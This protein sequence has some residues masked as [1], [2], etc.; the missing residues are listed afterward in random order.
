MRIK[1]KKGKQKE[2]LNKIKSNSGFT[3][4]EL[5]KFLEV[6]E[7]ALTEWYMERN[8]LPS[9]IYKKIDPKNEYKHFILGIKKDNWGKSK[10]GFNSDG[11]LKKIQIPKRC[12]ELAELIGI[13]LG[14]G[15]VF[16]YKKGKKIG[17]YSL[18]IAGD[19]KKDKNYHTNYII[20]LCQNLFDISVK[21]QEFK[22]NN[23]RFVS[24]Y[25]RELVNYLNMIGLKSG[26]KIKNSLTMP[27]WIFENKD[28]MKACIR[29]LIDTDGSVFRMSKKDPNLIRINFK[30]LN[31]R[32]LVDTR[33]IFIKLGYHPSKIIRN[34]VFY[35]SRKADITKYIKE[36][37]FSNEKHLRRFKE[38]NSSVV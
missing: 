20:P 8:L 12:K 23:E 19:L 21:T 33:K 28:Y 2:L 5:S 1:F 32:L 36:I 26:N 6:T 3:W 29:G 22:N 7:S 16:S 14:D 37:G 18:R 9:N 38:L 24:L 34:D 4:K 27:K 17:V 15:N 25:S 11:S 35:I 31:K 30:N 13:I 10:G